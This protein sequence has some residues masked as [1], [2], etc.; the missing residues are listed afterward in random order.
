MVG[1]NSG[2]FFLLSGYFALHKLAEQELIPI[3]NIILPEI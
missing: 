3:K 1:R 2:H